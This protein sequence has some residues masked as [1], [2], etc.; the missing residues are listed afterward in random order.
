M[1]HTLSS[2]TVLVVDDDPFIRNLLTDTLGM[3]GATVTAVETAQEALTTLEAWRPDVLLSD[4]QM[5]DR[6]GYW[7]IGQVRAL[8]PERGGTTPAACLTGLV[9]PEDR[10]RL[11]RA[12]FQYHIAKPVQLVRLIGIVRSLASSHE[13]MSASVVAAHS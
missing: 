1:D 4:L 9:E 12:G 13:A 3:Y 2:V 10:A 11:L 5:P 8:A 6:D 7:L